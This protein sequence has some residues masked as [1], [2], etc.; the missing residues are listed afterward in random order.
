MRF[1]LSPAFCL[2][3]VLHPLVSSVAHAQQERPEFSIKET[4]DTGIITGYLKDGEFIPS[5]E[6]VKAYFV[7]GTVDEDTRTLKDFIAEQPDHLGPDGAPIKNQEIPE[8]KRSKDDLGNVVFDADQLKE[9]RKRL[10][11]PCLHIRILKPRTT[12]VIIFPVKRDFAYSNGSQTYIFHSYVRALGS[13]VS[14]MLLR[15]EQARKEPA[16][17]FLLDKRTIKA[18][19]FDF[20]KDRFSL[21]YNV[22]N[23]NVLTSFNVYVTPIVIPSDT[24]RMAIAVRT[25]GSL[26]ALDFIG[27]TLEPVEL[28]APRFF[29]EAP[30]ASQLM[31]ELAEQK[32]KLQY[33]KLPVQSDEEKGDEPQLPEYLR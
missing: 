6:V 11:T 4:G 13:D 16:R 21:F 32:L 9:L 5:E 28:A 14:V 15:E 27:A 30:N 25:V 22:A 18:A 12:G 2:L 1:F 7:T 23:R 26:A 3:L 19:P 20:F 29:P 10:Q 24:T 17:K 31:K 8:I 33:P